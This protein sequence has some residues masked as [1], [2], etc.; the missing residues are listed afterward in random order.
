[1]KGAVGGRAMPPL[2]RARPRRRS[3]LRASFLTG[4]RERR[5]IEEAWRR[6][7]AGS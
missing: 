6:S 4:V 7:A 1:M 5:R 3:T 2:A